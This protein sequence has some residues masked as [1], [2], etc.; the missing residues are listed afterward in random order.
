MNLMFK[1]DRLFVESISDITPTLAEQV[2]KIL[3]EKVTEHLPP[4]WAGITQQKPALEWISN[5]IGDGMLCSLKTNSNQ[6]VIGFLL[7]YG[8]NPEA[9]SNEV[10]I[11]YVIAD[12][13]WGK[14]LASEIIH[15]LIQVFQEKGNVS[16]LVGGVVPE[17][18]GS[19]KVLTNNG[20]VFS[21]EENG[22]VFY[23]YKF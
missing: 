5:R 4:D 1:T 7:L 19:I 2:I 18:P 8:F 20:F 17:N 14:G 11:G 10:R 15:S 16:S 23:T 6:Q 3:S 22:S 9:Q 21:G 12:S 13:H